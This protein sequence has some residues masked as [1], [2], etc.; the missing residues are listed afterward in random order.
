[1]E[2]VCLAT[3]NMGSKQE[4]CAPKLHIQMKQQYFFV[5]NYPLIWVIQHFQLECACEIPVTSQRW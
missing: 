1:M 3:P 4:A 5:K 2:S